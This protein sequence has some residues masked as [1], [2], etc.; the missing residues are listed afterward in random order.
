[1]GEQLVQNEMLS[2]RS[3]VL[4]LGFCRVQLHQVP[5]ALGSSER[6]HESR[7]LP[8][9]ILR[10]IL[11]TL[12]SRLDSECVVPSAKLCQHQQN[13][14]GCNQPSGGPLASR[15]LRV[16]TP[17]R[18]TNWLILFELLQQRLSSRA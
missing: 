1:M 11:R 17:R 9:Q 4:C 18:C 5:S 10:E 14:R 13:V 12:V 8:L 16:L 2:S 3:F 15:V 7:L 6:C